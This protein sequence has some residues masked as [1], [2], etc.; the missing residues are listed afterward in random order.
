[1]VFLFCNNTQGQVRVNSSNQLFINHDGLAIGQSDFVLSSTN[2]TWAGMYINSESG[3][4]GRPFYGYSINGIP[5][6]YSYFDANGDKLIFNHLGVNKVLISNNDFIIGESLFTINTSNSRMYF[7][8]D[9]PINSFTDFT[10]RSNYNTFG[11]MFIDSPDP[12]NGKPFYGYSLDGNIGAYSFFDAVDNEW[13]LAIIKS[14]GYYEVLNVDS[15]TLEINGSIEL[16]DNVDTPTNTGSIFYQNGAFWGVTNS[17]PR[18]LDNQPTLSR[19][20]EEEFRNLTNKVNEL[21]KQN[22]ELK[23]II[24]QLYIRIDKIDKKIKKE[25]K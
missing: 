1:M 17:G 18:Q 9:S 15:T 20:E 8:T 10:L 22:D 23:A 16:S 5:K 3:T 19:I 7:N 13:K 11:G 6:S 24:E 4:S 14:E 21:E 12:L 2:G 25:K